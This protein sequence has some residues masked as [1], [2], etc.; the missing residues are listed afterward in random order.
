MEIKQ[1]QFSYGEKEFIKN[2]STTIEKGKITTIIGPNGSGKSTLLNLLVRQLKL[3]SGNIVLD[4]KNISNKSYKDIS[5][6]MAIVH[7]HNMGPH[8][9]TVK[10]L[11]SYGRTP[12]QNFWASSDSEDETIVDW[13]LEVT[14]VKSF[15]NKAISQLS[16]GER[17]R[18]WIAMALAQKTDIL[19]LDEPTTY[20][21]I[22]YQLEVLNLVK[23]LNETYGI[24]IIMVLHDINQAVQYSHNLIIM[25]EGQIVTTGNAHD[26]ITTDRLQQVYGIKANI[27]WSEEN[28]CPYMIPIAN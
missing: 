16:G 4:G 6:M 2:L 1:L 15:S 13:A 24:T 7:Q 14:G 28:Q 9:L 25:K 12:Y 5:K 3:Q 8:D 19:L 23:H 26:C 21:D 17:Q 22:F 10:G 18:A 20:L 11:V 27:F